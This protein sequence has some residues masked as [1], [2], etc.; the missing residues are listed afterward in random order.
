MEEINNPIVLADLKSSL[1][2]TTSIDAIEQTKKSTHENR[3]DDHNDIADMAAFVIE[4]LDE[5]SELDDDRM[6]SQDSHTLESVVPSL[7]DVIC[8]K[9]GRKNHHGNAQFRA[10]CQRLAP[11][12]LENP[13]PKRKEEVA[14][15]LVGFVYDQGGNFLDD[16]G[17]RGTWRIAEFAFALKKAKQLLADVKKNEDRASASTREKRNHSQMCS[18]DEDE[19][20]DQCL[21]KRTRATGTSSSSSISKIAGVEM[22]KASTGCDSNARD[23]QLRSVSP[24]H[25]GPLS[26][27][28]AESLFLAKISCRSD[29]TMRA[30]KELVA[31]H[32]DGLS[33]LAIV[34]SSSEIMLSGITVQQYLEKLSSLK[35]KNLS[36]PSD[37]DALIHPIVV[38]AL[39]YACTLG[40]GNV[41]NVAA[42]LKPEQIERQLLP[43]DDAALETLCALNV[44]CQSEDHED[45]EKEA[46]CYYSIGQVFQVAARERYCSSPAAAVQALRTNGLDAFARHNHDTWGPAVQLLPHVEALRACY[47]RNEM[48]F[49]NNN[50]DDND[51]DQLQCAD[52]FHLAG[53][54][55]MWASCDYAKALECYTTALDI[56]TQVPS[57]L[58][59]PHSTRIATTMKDIGRVHQALGDYSSAL[60]L[61]T[62]ALGMMRAADENAANPI[63]ATTI[64]NIGRVCLCLGQRQEARQHFETALHMKQEV[65]ATPASIALTMAN[66]GRICQAEGRYKEAL[67]Q[68][69]E[70]EKMHGVN[71]HSV[72]G[73]TTRL[74]EGQVYQEMGDLTGARRKYEQALQL[75]D[76]VFGI[77]AKNDAIA[78]AHCYLG[79]ILVNMCDLQ[80]AHLHLNMALEM[81]K[82]VFG[83]SAKHDNIANVTYHIGRL[84]E[85]QGDKQNAHIK[86]REAKTMLDELTKGEEGSVATSLMGNGMVLGSDGDM[87]R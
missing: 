20:Q 3:Q 4:S 75:Y 68:Y 74:C 48:V 71:Y 1:P 42:W 60:K 21:P 57:A 37:D 2:S 46:S 77:E 39:D 82:H 26:A 35:T 13:T 50:D 87:F 15:E 61:Y 30:T 12:F 80:G 69:Q 9:G 52:L 19:E 5:S 14:T 78:M 33:S 62:K 38:S 27:V 24:V 59:D 40:L 63:I 45:E 70:I 29:E 18:D 11:R 23:N 76:Q 65:Q 6:I 10:E 53:H 58:K 34:T 8:G 84:Y 67:V 86:Y 41:L 47:Q 31:E 16:S 85:K 44:L 55:F 54:V 43:A 51:D 22:Q 83:E 17:N 72:F 56:V 81:M 7:N 28:Q 32:F 25:A 66:L 36:Y 49:D 73:A 79:S 64:H